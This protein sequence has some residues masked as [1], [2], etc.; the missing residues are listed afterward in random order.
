[1]KL[2]CLMN[3][4]YMLCDDENESFESVDVVD[5][6]LSVQNEHTQTFL[7]VLVEFGLVGN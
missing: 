2:T 1:L 6:Q 3:V 7:I 4:L 5:L